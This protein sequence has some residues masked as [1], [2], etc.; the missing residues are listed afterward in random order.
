M[1]AE[2]PSIVEA[3]QCAVSIQQAMETREADVAEERRIR[4]RVGVN[5]GDIIFDEGDVYGDGVNIAARLEA[6]AEPG[7]VVV[8]GTAYDHLKSNVE[9][10]YEDLGEHAVKNIATPVRVYRVVPG[11][12]AILVRRVRRRWPELLAGLAVVA[13][14][15]GGSAWWWMQRAMSR[16]IGRH[17][18][19]TWAASIGPSSGA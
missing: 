12:K 11:G 6:L 18:Q 17:G 2:F 7:G 10:G 9:V 15:A 14:L 16:E 13:V 8:S 5:L 1:I 4:Y 3:V 19:I